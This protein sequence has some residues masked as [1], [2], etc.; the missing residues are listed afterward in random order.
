VR[1]RRIGPGA[2]GGGQVVMVMRD[3]TTERRERDW[4]RLLA[5]ASAILVSST[6]LA[7]VLDGLVDLAAGAIADRCAIVLREGT[8]EPRLAAFAGRALGAGAAAR[9]KEAARASALQAAIGALQ[10]A[11]PTLARDAGRSV[12]AAPVELRGRVG[13]AIVL[14]SADDRRRYG[15]PDLDPAAELA[16]RLAVALEDLRLYAEGQEALHA[17]ED[18]LAIVSHDLRN[19]LG[20]VLASSALLLKHP[21]GDPPG[22]EGR[23]KRQ[24][25]AI[26][27]A[28][29][30]MNRLIRDLLDFAAIQG[31]RL[32]VSAHPRAAGDLIRESLEALAAPAADKSLKLLDGSPETT[33][34]VSCDHDRAVQLLDNVVGN[35]VKFSPEG[36]TVTVRARAEGTMVLFSVADEGPGIPAA[37]LPFVFDRYYQARRRDRDGIG[38]GLS[39][40]R[41]IVQAHGG[42]IWV[43]SPTAAGGGGTTFFFTLPAAKS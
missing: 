7:K 24:V 9:D 36:G 34:Q 14:V 23:A 35:A 41:G 4:Q 19:P 12:L 38:L 26:Q 5:D 33:L 6:E 2:A 10:S 1:A 8:G 40:A 16:R 32:S 13:G 31:G 25:E 42:R 17:R 20:V 27:R 3:V 28:A 29:H 18:L 37:E 21:L 43:E 11:R 30:R 22:K 39:I 15:P